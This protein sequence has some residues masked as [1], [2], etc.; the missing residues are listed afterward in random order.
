MYRKF[1]INSVKY[2]IVYRVFITRHIENTPVMCRK[3]YRHFISTI[4]YI[5]ELKVLPSHF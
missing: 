1:I 4:I 2:V 5:A 3:L